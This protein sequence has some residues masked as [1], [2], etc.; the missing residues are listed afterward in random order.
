MKREIT[1]EL[2][3]S[4]HFQ[5]NFSSPASQRPN[6]GQL[7]PTSQI[8]WGS[9]EIL[10]FLPIWLQIAPQQNSPGS[11]R[12][13][14]GPL[15]GGGCN[16]DAVP[17]KSACI[18]QKGRRDQRQEKITGGQSQPHH[19]SLNFG[20]LHP[21]TTSALTV[22]LV[23]AL[24]ALPAMATTKKRKWKKISLQMVPDFSI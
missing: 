19:H 21:P 22:S 7:A 4:Q 20:M 8:S 18:I 23:P 9:R 10:L 3:Q 1:L 11:L 13:P 14:P 2:M 6:P 24:Q 12:S 5:L 16:E 15:N 17:R